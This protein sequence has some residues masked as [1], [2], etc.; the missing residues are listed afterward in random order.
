MHLAEQATGSADRLDRADIGYAFDVWIN[1]PVSVI[2]EHAQIW[3]EERLCHHHGDTFAA[4][5]REPCADGRSRGIYKT[6]PLRDPVTL[7][8]PHPEHSAESSSETADSGST[9]GKGSIALSDPS[10][11]VWLTF[12][13]SPAAD[14]ANAPEQRI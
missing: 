4:K 2:V 11:R 12:D 5:H 7:F 9:N 1:T 14:R 8:V 13:L 3:G 10:G 6:G